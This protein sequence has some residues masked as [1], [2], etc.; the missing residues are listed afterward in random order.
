MLYTDPNRFIYDFSRLQGTMNE[1]LKASHVSA[2]NNRLF[3][4]MKDK[5]IQFI[6]VQTRI[7]T[8]IHEL[9]QHRNGVKVEGSGKSVGIKD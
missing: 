7:D 2:M 4:L 6:G 3:T 5:V 9:D 8:E 1:Y